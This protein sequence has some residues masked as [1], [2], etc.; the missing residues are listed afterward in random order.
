MGPGQFLRLPAWAGQA[1]QGETRR[2]ILSLAAAVPLLAGSAALAK[3]TLRLGF[4]NRAL[5]QAADD[6]AQAAARA[7]LLR[8]SADAAV[9]RKLAR[10]GQMLFIAET[11]VLA[12]GGTTPVAGDLRASGVR[13]TLEARPSLPL[14]SL[15]L[16]RPATI[17]AE[18]SA[19]IPAL[20]PS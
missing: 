5:Q 4:Q 15:M 18:S 10:Q 9:Q 6:S 12:D 16:G 7:V 13:V 17:T 14:M 19:P 20:P 1:F 2:L 3:D 8:E 11:S